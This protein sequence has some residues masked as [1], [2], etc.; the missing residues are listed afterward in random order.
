[1]GSDVVLIDKMF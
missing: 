1:M